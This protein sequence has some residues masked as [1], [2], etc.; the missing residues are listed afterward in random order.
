MEYSLDESGMGRQLFSPDA[1]KN[2]LNIAGDARYREDIAGKS[3]A[4]FP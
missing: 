3:E 2:A 4:R 1:P